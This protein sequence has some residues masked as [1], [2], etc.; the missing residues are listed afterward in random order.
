VSS[1]TGRARAA[2]CALLLAAVAGVSTAADSARAGGAVPTCRTQSAELEL[3]IADKARSLEMSEECQ[4]RRYDALADVDG[5]GKDDFLAL[6]T[7][8][9]PRGANDHV[10]FLAA[11]L[12]GAPGRPIVVEAGRRGERDPVSIEARRGEIT[13]DVLEY[14]PGDPMC[15][16]S[17]KGRRVYRLSGG[18]LALERRAQR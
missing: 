4:F 2:A 12:S 17:G 1:R 11:F 8:E 13:L 14:L 3:L 9:G 15:C 5:D 18:R 7:L 16:P 6:F 10:T